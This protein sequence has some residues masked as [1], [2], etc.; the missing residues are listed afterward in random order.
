M[1]RVIGMLIEHYAG[2]LPAWLAPILVGIAN[3][4]DDQADYAKELVNTFRKAVIR[5]EADL[6]NIKMTYKIRELSLQKLPYIVVVGAK[7][8][9]ENKVAV[10]AR[11]GKDLGVMTIEEFIKLVQ[12][13][14]AERRNGQPD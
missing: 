8:K 6:R 3:I 12:Q 5:A 9:A 2:Q 4:T 11:G 1:E 10:R 14:V 13:D 7:E